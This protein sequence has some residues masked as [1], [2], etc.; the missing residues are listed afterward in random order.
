MGRMAD[1]CPTASFPLTIKG[2]SHGCRQREGATYRN[3]TVSSDGHLET[4]HAMVWSESSWFFKVQ[5]IISSRGNLFPFPWSQFS[6]LLQLFVFVFVV[7]Q[8]LSHVPL[9]WLHGMQPARLPCYEL[10][11]SVC[12]DSCPYTLW[13]YLTI[14][15]STIFFFFGFSLS[16]HQG[17]FQRKDYHIR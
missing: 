2:E 3:S 16:Q 14:S 10:C 17:L 6:E 12:S 9:L 5:L 1:S 15:S 7:V 4:D 13:C 8:L 11:P